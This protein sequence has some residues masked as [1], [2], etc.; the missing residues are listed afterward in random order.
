MLSIKPEGVEAVVAVAAWS[1]GEESEPWWW[2]V[3][4]S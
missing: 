4:S 1:E 3:C 2:S